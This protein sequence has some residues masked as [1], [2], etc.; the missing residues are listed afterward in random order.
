[1]TDVKKGPGEGL[2]QRLKGEKSLIG[3]DK[4]EGGQADIKTD[5]V[6]TSEGGSPD[7]TPEGQGAETDP[8]E[9]GQAA[10]GQV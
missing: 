8:P 10:S 2:D 7:F 1:M 9:Q 5:S 3:D 4:G 6:A